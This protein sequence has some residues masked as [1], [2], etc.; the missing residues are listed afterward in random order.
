MKRILVFVAMAVVSTPDIIWGLAN[1]VFAGLLYLFGMIVG[2]KPL[3]LYGRNIALSVD[4]F[5]ATK[6]MGQD[7]DVSISMALGVAKEKHL[8]KTARVSSFWLIFGRFVDWLFT[9]DPDHIRASIEREEK[10]KDTVITLYVAHDKSKD[11][12]R[13]VA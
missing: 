11:K 1:L 6:A 13:D 9:F 8:K 12:A 4:Q 10:A 5:L 2:S 7:P 3:K